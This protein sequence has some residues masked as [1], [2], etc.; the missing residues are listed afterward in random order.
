M[1][2]SLSIKKVN[3]EDIKKIM[4]KEKYLLISTLESN[5]QSCL[6]KNT[7]SIEDEEKLINNNMGKNIHIII[8]GKNTN[9]EKIYI[10]YKQ[11]LSLGFANVYVYLG[12]LFEWLCLQDIFGSESFP[13]TS[14]ELDILK[15]K[16]TSV[17]HF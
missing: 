3:F 1:G 17:L 14:K 10:K 5:H 4:Y 9:D 13:T 12:G 16:T 11:L 15:Y 6:I 7:V 2:S 8:Y